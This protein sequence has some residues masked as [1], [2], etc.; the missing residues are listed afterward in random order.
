M[1]DFPLSTILRISL[2]SVM[3]MASITARPTEYMKKV[4][5]EEKKASGKATVSENE[6][7]TDT[8][9]K[10]QEDFFISEFKDD[11]NDSTQLGKVTQGQE[12]NKETVLKKARVFEYRPP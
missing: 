6:N 5:E 10:K 9:G 4:I 11:K 8:A 7:K 1:Q 12:I 3:R 2:S